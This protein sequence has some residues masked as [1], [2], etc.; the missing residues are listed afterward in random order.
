MRRH[1]R[2]LALGL[3][4]GAAIAMAPEAFVEPTAVASESAEQTLADL[5][6]RYE[7]AEGNYAARFA[8]VRA[9]YEALANEHAGTEE[10][11]TALLFLLRNTWWER[12]DGTMHESAGA[13]VER[14][15]AD[16]AESPRLVGIVERKYV[17]SKAQRAE[18]FP[19]LLEESPHPVVQAEALLAIALAAPDAETKQ[20][21]LSELEERF[22]EVLRRELTPYAEYAAAHREPH[23][24][25]ALAV[26]EVAPDI[27][28]RDLDG[29]PLRLSDHRGKVVVL[30]F[31]GD[32]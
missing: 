29:K 20:S 28:G 31:W 2:T 11:L 26:G 18:L 4:L 21:R 24:K 6:A 19:R 1:I 9:D 22:G 10:A 14:I 17:L 15:M 8:G 30:D 16:H 5:E 7:A 13:L 12:Q 25:A 3:V 32:W 27:V 23:G